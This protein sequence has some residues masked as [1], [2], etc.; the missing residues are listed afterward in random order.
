MPDSPEHHEPTDVEEFTKLWIKS[1]HAV[2]AFIRGSVRNLHDA[3]DLLQEVAKES[4][5]NFARFDRS[6]PF[7]SWLIGIARYRVL[8]YLRRRRRDG[9]VLLEEE[10]LEA[11]ADAHVRSVEDVDDRLSSL[12]D[13]MGGLPER[14]RQLLRDRYYGG[15]T[16][17]QIASRIGKTPSSVNQVFYRIRIA[18]ANCIEQRM[19][20]QR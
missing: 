19:G 16:A 10:T 9:A 4:S 15:L 2:A 18:L 8:D 17:A 6:R 13:C 12:R 5:R 14:Q 20:T 3:E 11:L 1:H 7:A